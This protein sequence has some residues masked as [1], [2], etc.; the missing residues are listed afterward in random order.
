MKQGSFSHLFWFE[1]VFFSGGKHVSGLFSISDITIRILGRVKVGSK[2]ATV[3][4]CL[5]DQGKFLLTNSIFHIQ[6]ENNHER[7]F[8]SRLTAVSI[9]IFYQFNSKWFGTDPEC[10]YE[11]GRSIRSTSNLPSQHAVLP[12]G[13][14][15]A[16]SS[17]W[18][19]LWVLHRSC[20]RKSSVRPIKA[21]FLPLS[22]GYELMREEADHTNK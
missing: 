2:T 13:H 15:P 11:S 9:Y 18:Q 12:L 4:V 21:T 10:V 20:R 17:C 19:T 22:S 7:P 16:L 6:L 5:G 14:R 1:K 8:N 3:Y